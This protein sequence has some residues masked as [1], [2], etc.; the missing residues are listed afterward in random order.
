MEGLNQATIASLNPLIK[1]PVELVTDAPLEGFG[2][3]PSDNYGDYFA[4]QTGLPYA[5]MGATGLRTKDGYN[6]AQQAGETNRTMLNMLLG[7]KFTDYTNPGAADYAIREKGEELSQILDDAGYEDLD[8]R[9][10]TQ[11]WKDYI[12]TLGIV[13]KEKSQR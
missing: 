4:G 12:S 7:M 13:G 8:K 3:S 2:K 5:L 1:T 9:E 6:E 11:Q 10:A